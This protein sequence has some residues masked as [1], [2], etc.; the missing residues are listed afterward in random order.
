ML[1]W[2]ET[3]DPY[4]VLVSEFMLQ[5]TQVATVI[6]YYR[7]WMERYPGVGVLARA[8]EADVL[9]TWQG[10]G[11]YSRCRNLL[12]AARAISDRHGGVVPD[13]FEALVALPGVGRYTAAAVLAFA[14]GKNAPVVDANIARVIARITNFQK[15][16]STSSG[17]A[18]LESAALE[19]AGGSDARH[20]H[21]A[22]MELGALVCRARSPLC[23]ECPVR[24]DCAAVE[25]ERLP[26]KAARPVTTAV[27]EQRGFAV[28]GEFLY[29]QLSEGPRWKGLWIMPEVQ[30]QAG[31]AEHVE[32]YPITRYRVTMEVFRLTPLE[33]AGCQAVRLG[34]FQSLAMPAPH[35]RA[36]EVI[37]F[38]PEGSLN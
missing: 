2:R 25:P 16:I 17:K 22:M 31:V 10:L 1:P 21:S 18:Y 3:R 7:R 29:L 34:E 28:D 32:I 27:T 37:L 4:A 35:R 15:A 5:Q 36:L 24:L 26:V 33:L 13:S 6:D 14:F 11:Y 38:P 12:A 9:S 8:D 20:H 30:G 19:L 23:L